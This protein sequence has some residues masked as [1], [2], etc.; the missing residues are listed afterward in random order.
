MRVS[1]PPVKAVLFD[2]HG[3]LAQVEEP[4]DWV[5]NAAAALGADLTPSAARRLADELILAGRAGGPLP[6]VVPPS[7]RTAWDRRDLTMDDHRTAYTALAAG[8]DSGIDG[9]PTALY[10][11][12]LT[13]DGWRAYAD[14]VPVLR[15]LHGAGVRVA[16]VSN[17]GFDVRPVAEGLG[18]APFV[19]AYALSY[20]VGHCKPAPEIFRAACADLGVDPRDTV[21][22]GDTPADAGAVS[23]GCRCLILPVSPAGAEHGLAA[24][25]PLLD[26]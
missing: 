7:V 25:L 14:A 20:E 17:I 10:D 16:V 13:P 6:S 9:L 21:M 15:R 24:V 18:L 22:V 19:D 12:L 26:A 11:R 3:T 8:V 23:A 5:L 4:T 1:S 2:F